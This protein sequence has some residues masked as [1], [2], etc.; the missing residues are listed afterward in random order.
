MSMA[1]LLAMVLLVHLQFDLHAE[2]VKAGSTAIGVR[3]RTPVRVGE[4]LEKTLAK[5]T[6]A[7][8]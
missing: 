6:L 2:S 3:G 1:T 5:K 7:K 8:T 4:L